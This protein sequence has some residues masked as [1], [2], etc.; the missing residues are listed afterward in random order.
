MR[1]L[2]TF[3]G[4]VHPPTN[5]TQSLRTPIARAPLPGKL[6]IPFHQHVGNIAKPLVKVGESK[7]ERRVGSH[8]VEQ[9]LQRP[10]AAATP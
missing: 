9:F 3:H 7:I 1:T 5:K 2:Y 4:G 6:V 8:S 10:G